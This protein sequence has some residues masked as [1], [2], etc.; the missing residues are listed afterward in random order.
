M[1]LE[2]DRDEEMNKF[3]RYSKVIKHST[4]QLF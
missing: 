2:S 1:S 3:E 4:W